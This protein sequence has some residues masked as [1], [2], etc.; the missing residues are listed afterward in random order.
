MVFLNSLNNKHALVIGINYIG[1]NSGVLNG[2]INDTLK[3][4]N[5]LINK[6]N[7][8]EENIVIITDETV[9]KPTK[10][11]IINALVKLVENVKKDNSKEVWFSYSGHGYYYSSS[12]EEDSQDEVLVPLDYQKNGCIRDDLLYSVLVKELPK[13]CNLFSIIDACHSGTS[14]DLPYIYRTNSG[15][16]QQHKQNKIANVVKI[17][18]CRDD[19]TSAD[20]LI[21]GKYQ[22]ALTFGFLRSMESMD[23]NFTPRQLIHKIERYLNENG[24]TQIPTLTFSNVNLI[25][26]CI[27]GSNNELFSNPNICISL[28]GDSWCSEETR[29]NIKCLD[30]NKNIFITDRKFHQNNEKVNYHVNL[31]DGNYEL[32]IMDSYGDGGVNGNIYFLESQKSIK[33]IE[34]SDGVHGIYNFRINNSENIVEDI[35]EKDIRIRLTGDRWCNY[36]SEW[37]IL[38]NN[39]DQLY[40]SDNKFTSSSEYQ[41]VVIKLKCGAYKLKCS[42][43]WGDGGIQGIINC[44]KTNKKLLTFN[45]NSGSLKYYN[46]YV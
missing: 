6:C 35:E 43:S 12:T 33:V 38:D 32:H 19:Q 20:A 25:D 2:C 13:D 5:F 14:L 21:N 10:E 44:K 39:G 36:E 41:D 4:K 9:V 24:Y 23:Y 40:D 37:N 26:E 27:M 1:H 8:K 30:S 18:G 16:K 22:G 15:I 42:D 46:F 28:E 17:S 11:N 7:Y 31:K 34:F 45:F 3:I 29:W